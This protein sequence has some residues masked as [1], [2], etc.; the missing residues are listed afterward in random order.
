MQLGVRQARY[1]G[2]TKTL[3]QLLLA[4]TVANLTLVAS[5][6]GLMRDRN[7]IRAHPSHQLGGLLTTILSANWHPFAVGTRPTLL[8]RGRFSA[9]LLASNFR[10]RSCEATEF[11][12]DSSPRSLMEGLIENKDL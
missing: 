11:I 1:V 2:R 7:H 3:C 12:A 9:T 10:W 8:L 4:A 6:V 5:G